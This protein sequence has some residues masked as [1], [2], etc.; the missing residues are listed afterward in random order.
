MK[1]RKFRVSISTDVHGSEC[2][3]FIEISGSA[4]EEEIEEEAKECAMN[5]VSWYYEEIKDK[6]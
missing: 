5:M 2:E 6:E 3:D 1:K 4:S